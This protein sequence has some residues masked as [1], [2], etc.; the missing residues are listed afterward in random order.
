MEYSGITL[1]NG[2]QVSGS[3]LS[4]LS[5]DE[6]KEL[7]ETHA[8]KWDILL[9]RQMHHGI[10]GELQRIFSSNDELS[11]FIRSEFLS[12]KDELIVE[13]GNGEKE[14][15]KIKVV[16]GELYEQHKPDRRRKRFMQSVKEYRI[17]LIILSSAILFFSVA[18]QE[19]LTVLLEL[20]RENTL[21]AIGMGMI[22]VI[23]IGLVKWIFKKSTK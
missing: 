11:A 3:T 16:L 7:A 4:S 2:K 12:L 18:F 23:I 10:R 21:K 14:L 17:H 9:L 20:V 19:Y 6:V 5:P 8:T 22:P 13:T 1:K 15:R